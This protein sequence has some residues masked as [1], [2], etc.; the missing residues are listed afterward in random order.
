MEELRT[1]YFAGLIDGEGSI[2]MTSNGAGKPKRLTIEVK[3]SCQK[4]IK[5]IKDHFG[6]GHIAARPSTT[7]GW[8]DQWRWRATG[9]SARMVLDAVKPY[10]ITKQDIA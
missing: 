2:G 3:M 1:A 10:L 7:E 9:P 4:T 8:R 6:V 5:A